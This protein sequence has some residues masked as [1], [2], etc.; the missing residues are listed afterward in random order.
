MKASIFN[1]AIGEFFGEKLFKVNAP[2]Y[3]TILS[4]MYVVCK[5]CFAIG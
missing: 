5:T 3:F 1:S 2:K 4:L